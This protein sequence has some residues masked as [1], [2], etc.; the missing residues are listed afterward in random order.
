MVNIRQLLA[1]SK[2]ETKRI[3]RHL[4]VKVGGHEDTSTALLSRALT[5]QTVDLAVVVNLKVL[6]D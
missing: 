4:T 1:F 5:A 3:A 2:Q 6:N